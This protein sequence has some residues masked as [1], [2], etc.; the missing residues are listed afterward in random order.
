MSVEEFRQKFKG[1]PVKRSK[2]RGL[3]RN[4]AAALSALKE[5]ATE[6]A[7]TSMLDHEEPLVRE[8]ARLSLTARELRRRQAGAR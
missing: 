6:A 1:S 7:L 3:M 2:W 4:A 8:Q 5:P